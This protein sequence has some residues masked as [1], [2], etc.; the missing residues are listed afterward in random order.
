MWYCLRWDRLYVYSTTELCTSPPFVSPHMGRRCCE[1]HCLHCLSVCLP[2]CIQ[3]I[4][5]GCFWLDESSVGLHLGCL[6][7][8]N[9]V[10]L[11]LSQLFPAVFRCVCELR[12]PSSGDLFHGPISS[13][14]HRWTQRSIQS[15]TSVTDNRCD[16]TSGGTSVWLCY[17]EGW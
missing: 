12:A 1:S 2:A 4:V 17:T 10:C 11:R 8:L 7:C 9:L 14:C 16:Q 13:L 5:P 6:T 3:V 15:E